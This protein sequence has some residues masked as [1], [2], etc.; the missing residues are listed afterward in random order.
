MKQIIVANFKMNKTSFETMEY[1]SV[2]NKLLPKNSDCEIVVCLPYT[3]LYLAENFNKKILLGA[4]N[5]CDE[6]NGSNTGEISA[7]MLEDLNVRYVLVG[8][9]DR[10]RRFSETNEKINKKIKVA[11]KRGLKVVLCVGE[12]KAHRFAKRTKEVL[13]KQIVTALN[14]IYE[15]ELNGIIIAYEPV[16][17]VGTGTIAERKQILDA[18]NIIR[19]IIASHYCQEAGQ[20][21]RII[22]GGSITSQTC[23]EVFKNESINGVLVGTASLDPKEFAKIVSVNV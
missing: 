9:S 16:W 17:A 23:K 10:R 15:N 14:G 7:N 12:T 2:F 4:Q 21:Q 6:E 19:G 18:S 11:L 8:H 5:L 22:Y 3:S 20:K 13:T 1:I